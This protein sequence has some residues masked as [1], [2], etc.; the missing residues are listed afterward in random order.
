MRDGALLTYRLVVGRLVSYRTP[1]RLDALC[2]QGNCATWTEL[3]GQASP[4]IHE[5]SWCQCYL[6][7]SSIGLLAFYNVSQ[8]SACACLLTRVCIVCYLRQLH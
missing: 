4:Q 5:D 2:M 7:L 6:E 1:R 8:V 3:L